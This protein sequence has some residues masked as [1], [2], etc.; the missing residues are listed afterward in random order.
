MIKYT[1]K[2]V[3]GHEFEAWFKD[4]KAY[5]TMQ[6]AKQ[7]SCAV[8]G[9]ERVEKTIMAP[10]LGKAA[11]ASDTPLSKPASPAE[12][13]LARLRTHI[14]E[15]SDYVGKGFADEARKMHI[16]ESEE[17]AIWGEATREDAN[18]LHDEGVPVAPIP[19]MTRTD[20]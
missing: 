1:L 12:V 15:N 9:S 13:A 18:A 4:S 6:K 2:C 11:D 14:R 19:W 7:V 20:D 10:A 3:D 5:E 8:C 16:G 17:R